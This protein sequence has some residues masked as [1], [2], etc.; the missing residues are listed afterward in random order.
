MYTHSQSVIGIAHNANCYLGI[1]LNNEGVAEEL[2]G[3]SYLVVVVYSKIR[4]GLL[5]GVPN[6]NLDTPLGKGTKEDGMGSKGA[7]EVEF[8]DILYENGSINQIQK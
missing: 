2:L 6:R 4:E 7:K 3:F 8:I 5:A 1:P